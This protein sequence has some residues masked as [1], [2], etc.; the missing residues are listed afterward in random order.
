MNMKKL[1]LLTCTLLFLTSALVVAQDSQYIAIRGGSGWAPSV[2]RSVELEVGKRTA[3]VDF[4]SPYSFAGA[5]GYKLNDWFRLE[6]E[7]SYLDVDIDEVT[8]HFGQDSSE[9]GQDEYTSLMINALGD[10]NNST[11][12]TPFVGF[13]VGAVYARHDLEFTL[14]PDIPTVVSDDTQWLFGYQLMAGVTW[15]LQPNIS[16]E[17]MYRFFGTSSRTHDQTN[18]SATEAANPITEVKLDPSQIH[19]IMLGL[20][21]SF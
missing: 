11:A 19:Q 6:A 13:G 9:T 21:Y 18:V 12:F 8:G 3:N 5:Y 10:L 15:Q 14:S 17:C 7:L 4:G 2:D 20:R 1:L 16:L